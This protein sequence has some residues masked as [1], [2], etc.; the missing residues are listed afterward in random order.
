MRSR[1]G[2]LHRRLAFLCLALLLALGLAAASPAHDALHADEHGS[3]VCALCHH[4]A[5]EAPAA[6]RPSGPRIA[7]EPARDV[8]APEPERVAPKPLHAARA[9]PRA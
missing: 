9:P 5:L 7:P 4:S 1:S 3:H 2:E 6:P 8:P